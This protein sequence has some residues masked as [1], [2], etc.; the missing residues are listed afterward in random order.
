MGCTSVGV[1]LMLI[2][3]VSSLVSPFF[4]VS[5][6]QSYSHC[7]VYFFMSSSLDFCCN[8][9]TNVCISDG[10]HKL[11]RWRIVVHGAIDGFS[12]LVLFLRGSTNNKAV[13]V[14]GHFLTAVGKYGLPSRIRMDQGGENVMVARHMLRHRGA[15]RTSVLVG[16]SVHNLA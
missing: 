9:F 8:L 1:I 10:Q 2:Q 12:R 7:T 16:S 6:D 14:F 15:D 3:V 5:Y 4:R 11:I 13:T